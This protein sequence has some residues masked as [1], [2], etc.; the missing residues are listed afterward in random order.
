MV[1]LKYATNWNLYFWTWDCPLWY[2]SLYYDGWNNQINL[3]FICLC[4][5]TPPLKG[6]L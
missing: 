4:W 1:R 5:V 6:D 2:S 3:G